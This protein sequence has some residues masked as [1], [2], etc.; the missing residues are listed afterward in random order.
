MNLSREADEM[1]GELAEA[2]ATEAT[3]VGDPVPLLVPEAEERS[4]PMDTR[5]EDRAR[6]S[7]REM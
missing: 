3:D 4:L 6:D 5:G 2:V 1:G 7:G